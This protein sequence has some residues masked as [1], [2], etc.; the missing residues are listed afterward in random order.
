MT[1]EGDMRTYVIR[2]ILLIIPTVLIVSMIV[3]L[4]V[5]LIPGDVID[6]MMALMGP[7]ATS[8]LGLDREAIE[9]MLGLDVSIPIQ[10][11]RWMGDIIL[12]G[13]L[14]ESLRGGPNVTDQLFSRLPVTIELGVLAV[15]VGLLIALPIG[16]YSAIRQDTLGDY[17]GRTVGI[18]F[19]CIPNFW[20]GTIVMIYPSIWWGWTPPMELVKFADDPLG[21]LGM[22]TIPAVILGASMAGVTMRMTRTTMLE[23]LRQDYVRT[24]WS[25]GLQGEG[26]HHEAHPEECVH[27]SNYHSRHA[28]ASSS[29]RCGYYGADIRPAR[30]RP[31]V[32]RRSH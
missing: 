29:C 15:I 22:F 18:L 24:A 25:K 11:G 16:I 9:H 3:F 2:R 17:G 20:L 14:G 10:Y 32:Y 13:N 31:S 6:M 7:E 12:R 8:G 30:G 4:S 28:V 21:N 26:G 27:P 5:R 1:R 19:L 23:V